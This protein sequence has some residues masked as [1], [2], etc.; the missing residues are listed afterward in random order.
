MD[1]FQIE[2]DY[3]D[4]FVGKNVTVYLAK[5]RDIDG[6]ISET[7]TVLTHYDI[8]QWG[9]AEIQFKDC[10]NLIINTDDVDMDDTEIAG[11]EISGL[12]FAIKA[13]A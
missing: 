10:K 9:I 13:A 8:D 3:L 1:D 6:E 5:D 12:Y 2:K 7:K 11:D 4:K